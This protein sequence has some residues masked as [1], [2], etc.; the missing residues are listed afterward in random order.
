[1]KVRHLLLGASVIA[2]LGCTADDSVV[3][4]ELQEQFLVNSC[5]PD[6]LS[7]RA[8]SAEPELMEQVTLAGRIYGGDFSPFDPNMAAF[9][10]I[11]LPEP[12][13]SHEDPGDCPFCK[14][15][16]DNAEMVVVRLLGDDGQ[17]LSISVDKMLGLKK[18]Q[19]VVVRGV[20]SRVDDLLMVNATSV[21]VL[22]DGE[23]MEL[24]KKF[25][26]AVRESSE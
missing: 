4:H 8:V 24:S 19:D 26:L 1:M 13:H 3:V 7:I 16:A 2:C 18:N 11:D 5:P 17:P 9:T 14:H 21:H 22:D 6:P 12:G 20:P 25:D 10:M 15:K 23:A